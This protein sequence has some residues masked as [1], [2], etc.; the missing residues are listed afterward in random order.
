MLT[1]K[2]KKEATAPSL[3]HK[4]D[5]CNQ[6]FTAWVLMLA[7]TPLVAP[8]FRSY[9]GY[10]VSKGKPLYGYTPD[11][12]MAS[13]LQIGTALILLWWALATRL[14][15][16]RSQHP[17]LYAVVAFVG[18]VL[19]SSLWSLNGYESLLKASN[20]MAALCGLWLLVQHSGRLETIH[21]LFQ[22]IFISVVAIAAFGIGQYLWDWNWLPQAVPPA[23]TFGNKNFVAHYCLFGIP[24]GWLLFIN[25]R[26]FRATCVYALGTTIILTFIVYTK[27]RAAWLGV[28]MELVMLVVWLV[29]EQ[30]H[31]KKYWLHKRHKKVLFGALLLF[32]GAIHVGPQGLDVHSVKTLAKEA[33]SI[34]EQSS[35]EGRNQRIPIWSNSLYLIRDHWLIGVGIGNWYVQYPRY[36]QAWL[37]DSLLSEKIATRYAHNDFIQ[38]IAELGIVGLALITL[39]IVLTLRAAWRLLQQPDAY[40]RAAVIGLLSALIGIILNAQFSSPLQR[41]VPSYLLLVF[42]GLLVWLEW[43]SKPL[44]SGTE[45]QFRF[46]PIVYWLPVMAFCVFLVIESS[47]LHY[48]Q[49]MAN[50]YYWKAKAAINQKEYRQA[51]FLGSLAYRLNPGRKRLLNMVGGSHLYLKQ[52]KKA[53][54]ALEQVRRAYPYMHHSLFNLSYAYEK[55]GKLAKSLQIMSILY[56]IQWQNTTHV[57]RIAKL[58]YK[59]GEAIKAREWAQKALSRGEPLSTAD[60]QI[61]TAILGS[62]KSEG[63]R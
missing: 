34:L 28:L 26:T 27:T 46:K 16:P 29:Y 23:S 50:R 51:V 45:W 63:S 30:R 24:I 43:H 41:P 32:V 44:P 1:N 33:Y 19:I 35:A 25:S 37:K 21:R 5:F 58:F 3:R 31:H 42:I 11:L 52:Y 13:W 59:R 47:A 39:I 40:T 54:T 38:L 53:A 15:I 14:Q 6:W 4:L 20:W 2:H 12:Y 9:I 57:V 60:R 22:A 10:E 61:V 55:M 49:L 17:L 36:Q 62:S 56:K 18:W 7:A 8:L 48:R